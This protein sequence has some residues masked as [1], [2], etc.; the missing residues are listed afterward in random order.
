MTFVR[1]SPP[2]PTMPHATSFAQSTTPR[3]AT[4]SVLLAS[5]A[6][7]QTESFG[8]TPQQRSRYRLTRLHAQGG[9]GRVW[10]AHD[11]ELNRDVALK[12]IRPEQAG[13]PEAWWRFVKECKSPG[14]SSTR[15][16]S[17]CTIL[18]TVPTTTS[19]FTRCAS[20]REERS[21]R[22]SPTTTRGP[23]RRDPTHWKGLSCCNRSWRPAKRLATAHSRG[24]I[25]RDLKP[26]NVVLDDYGVVMVLDW[27]LAR[28]VDRPDE[29]NE[30]LPDVSV[31]GEVKDRETGTH[32]LL[33]TPAYMAPEQAQGRN[34]LVDVQT[35]IYGLGAILFEILIGRPPHSGADTAE[36]VHRVATRKTPRAR[37]KDASVPRTLDAICGL[38]MARSKAD[39]YGSAAE[40]A[41]DVERW[42]VDE[43]V[44]G[45]TFATALRR[46]F[47]KNPTLTSWLFAMLFVDVSLMNVMF[48]SQLQGERRP[49][50]EYFV[51]TIFHLGMVFQFWLMACFVFCLIDVLF[52]WRGAEVDSS[53]HTTDWPEITS[54]EPPR[55][56]LRWLC[57]R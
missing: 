26:E 12:E 46:W 15:G 53:R 2:L 55:S 3:S 37:Q 27:G 35:D 51:G 30:I 29:Y 7:A 28:T 24:V 33:G 43:P 48:G 56:T 9:L 57:S 8:P 25:H 18:P 13:H 4:R 52:V 1:P 39:R 31:T 40:L 45:E 23:P 49:F 42:L 21:A 10:V 17:L 34:E 41:E 32:A 36:I 11:R 19:R 20:S 22:R 50:H 44:K 5:A 16:S 47:R 6:A 54:A 14:N 38:A